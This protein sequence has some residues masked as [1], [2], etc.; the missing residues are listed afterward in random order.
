MKFSLGKE[1]GLTLSPRVEALLDRLVILIELFPIIDMSLPG[2]DDSVQGAICNAGS[3]YQLL[4]GES[5]TI[6]FQLCKDSLSHASDIIRVWILLQA[7]SAPIIRA[8]VKWL[9]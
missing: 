8:M 7:K 6:P 9:I 1:K 4:Q 3:G 5:A 2:R